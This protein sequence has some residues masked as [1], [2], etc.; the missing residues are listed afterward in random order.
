MSGARLALV[1]GCICTSVA[2]AAAGSG[3]PDPTSLELALARGRDVYLVVER[4]E[5]RL[6]I[7]VRGMALDSVP[8]RDVRVVWQ[9]AEVDTEALGALAAPQVWRVVEAPAAEW[10]R[11]VAPEVLVPYD[12]EADPAQGT[13]AAAPSPTPP[14]PRPDRFE[15][16]TDSGWRLAVAPSV[17]A[18]APL[19][20]WRR[21]FGG[22]RRIVG[23]PRPPLDPTLVLVV[24]DGEDARRLVHLFRP[25]AAV[26]VGGES[27]VIAAPAPS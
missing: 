9:G 15:V 16:S 1:L 5:L 10:R 13:P 25:G 24:S 27:P 4:A 6:S 2:G 3:P 26:L 7:R 21:V 17:E 19:G 8:L 14:P 18:V 22:W 11:V 23:R 20:V 12:E